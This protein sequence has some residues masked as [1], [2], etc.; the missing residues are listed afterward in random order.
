MQVCA[1]FCVAVVPFDNKIRRDTMRLTASSAN[2][3]MIKS[4][5]FLAPNEAVE[6]LSF[7]H[8][9]PLRQVHQHRAI[10]GYMKEAHGPLQA[11][12]HQP[13]FIGG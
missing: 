12:R 8:L 9:A 5:M 2:A 1:N 6:K 3:P 13:P 7:L 4:S 10:T 11:H